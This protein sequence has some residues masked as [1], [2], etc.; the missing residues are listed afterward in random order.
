VRRFREGEDMRA[1]L[2]VL[3][4][5]LRVARGLVHLAEWLLPGNG[6]PPAR[7]IDVGLNQKDLAHAIGLHRATVAT[8]IAK[9][10]QQGVVAINRRRIVVTDLERLRALSEE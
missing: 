4:S 8:E 6:I 3:P 5:R 10:R 2:A 9:L 1:E 7:G